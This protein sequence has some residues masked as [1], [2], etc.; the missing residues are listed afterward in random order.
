MSD[1]A[2][3]RVEGLLLSAQHP[4]P[5]SPFSE[6]PPGQ[7]MHRARN[8][9]PHQMKVKSLV[10]WGELHCLQSEQLQPDV[11]MSQQR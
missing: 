5:S 7:R 4:S 10:L 3:S 1:V 8:I 9:C 2:G 6:D 11:A